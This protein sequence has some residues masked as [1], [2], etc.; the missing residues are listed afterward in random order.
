MG[1]GLILGNRYPVFHGFRGGK[2]VAAY[3]GFTAAIMPPAAGIACLAWLAAFLVARQ[4]FI[5]SFCMIAIL[6]AGTIYHLGPAWPVLLGTLPTL[7]LIGFAHQSNISRYR[8][9]RIS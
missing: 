4:P 6:G 5:G 7:A 3:L 1:L 9:G 8:V 2:G